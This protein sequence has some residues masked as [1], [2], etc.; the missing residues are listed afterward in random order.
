MGNPDDRLFLSGWL[1][2]VVGMVPTAWS[3]HLGVVA[4]AV[5]GCSVIYDF[6]QGGLSIRISLYN[7]YHT[8]DIRRSSLF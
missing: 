6:Y 4:A 5:C 3:F 2:C 1:G 7:R 8:M